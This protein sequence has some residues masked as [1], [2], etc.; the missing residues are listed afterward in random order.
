M[1]LQQGGL[2]VACPR[3]RGHVR[4]RPRSVCRPHAHE[5]VGMPPGAASMPAMTEVVDRRGVSLFPAYSSPRRDRRHVLEPPVQDGVFGPVLVVE[6]PPL[7]LVDGEALVFHGPAEPLATPAL[8]R[9]AA[10]VVGAR[11][12]RELVVTAD[13]LDRLPG[14]QHVQGQVDGAAAVVLRALRRVGDEPPAPRGR[15]SPPRTS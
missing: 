11:P 13:H 14:L 3:L 7:D 1:S 9:G 4:R 12:R 5:D 15:G 6:V 2:W 10:R 8:E